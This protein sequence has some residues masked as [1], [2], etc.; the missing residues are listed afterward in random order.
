MNRWMLAAVIGLA[1][2][3]GA[4]WFRGAPAT[5]PS[6][7]QYVYVCSETGRTIVA[8]A[9]P[10]PAVNPETGRR[11]LLRGLYCDQC[12]KW[13]PVPPAH[14]E[15]TNPLHQRCPKHHTPLSQNGP[16]RVSGAG[17]SAD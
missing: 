7:Q 8:A 2:I 16:L 13:Y 17:D 14:R 11:T 1:A 6:Q 12:R 15:G 5:R 9:E 10:T 3:G 4:V